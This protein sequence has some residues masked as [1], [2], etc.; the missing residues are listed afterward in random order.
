[1]DDDPLRRTRRSLEARGAGAL[2]RSAVIVYYLKA[3]PWLVDGF[4]VET[5]LPHLLALQGQLERGW[6]LRPEST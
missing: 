2:Q 5:H 4:S 6:S 1:M 3:V